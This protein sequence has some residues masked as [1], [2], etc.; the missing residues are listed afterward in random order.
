MTELKLYLA[1]RW[2]Q[3]SYIATLATDLQSRGFTITSRWLKMEHTKLSKQACA[4]VDLEDIDEANI[5]V[6]F[7]E[8]PD[9]G[10]NTGGRHV[11]FGYAYAEGKCLILVGPVENIFHELPGVIKLDSFAQ[12]VEY[13]EK[14][15]E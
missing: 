7:T 14:L 9:V 6:S 2:Q 8:L 13:L 15:R 1:G 4:T 3:R 5:L 12:L 10:Y 11:E